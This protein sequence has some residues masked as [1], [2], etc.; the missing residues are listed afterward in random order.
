MKA[1]CICAA[2]LVL[3]GCATSRPGVV[4]GV[5]GA[6]IVVAIASGD[7]DAA[8]EKRECYHVVSPGNNGISSQRVCP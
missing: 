2:A 3:S 4:G 6:L 7:D 5:I 1:L 8:P